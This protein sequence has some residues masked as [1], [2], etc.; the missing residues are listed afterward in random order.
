[1]GLPRRYSESAGITSLSQAIRTFGFDQWAD[2]Y[3]PAKK[4][5]EISLTRPFYPANP[6]G[7]K[8]E[9]LAD[10]LGVA[11]VSDLLR[12][13]DRKTAVGVLHARSY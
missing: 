11:A 6:R 4:P 2:F 3:N 5:E 7:T 8:K 1:M 13:C 9:Q 10:A 12:V